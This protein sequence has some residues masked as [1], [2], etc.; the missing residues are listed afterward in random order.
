MA[1]I[2]STLPSLK[3]IKEGESEYRYIKN[4][5]LIL[6]TRYNNQLYTTKMQPSSIPPVLD[7]KL[8]IAIGERISSSLSESEFIKADGSIDFKGNQSHGGNNITGVNN[9]TVGNALDVDGHTTLDQVTVNTTDGS[10]AVSG[11]N[12][13]TLTTTGTNDIDITTAQN[14]DVGIGV[15]YQ[16]DVTRTCDWNTTNIDWDNSA[17]FDLT[18]VGDL[19]IETSGAASAKTILLFN[20]N[21]HASAFRGIH[22]KT[23][24]Q[25][26]GSSQNSIFIECD[27]RAAKGGGIGVDIRSEDGVLIRGED[28]T[29][30]DKSIVQI[31]ATGSVDIAGDTNSIT[32]TTSSPHRVKIHGAFDTSNLYRADPDVAIVM[33]NGT[34]AGGSANGEYTKFQALDTLHLVRAMTY[35]AS[36]TV[37][38]TASHPIVSAANDDNAAG[39]SW[40]ITIVWKH[41]S[42]DV[43][44]QL[45]M[46]SAVGSADNTLI[47]V[48]ISENLESAT[49]TAAGTLEWTNGA[50]IVWTNGHSDHSGSDATMKASALRIQSGTNDF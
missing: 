18:S 8:N 35:K 30:G 17:D 20:D 14:L 1:R 4:V 44:S 32:A 42:T 33:D 34:I 6:Y 37:A 38:R 45:W 29:N 47:S 5:G 36:A 10:F 16:L 49:G 41:A 24:S 50:G 22:L 39:T 7:K 3:E 31:R 46:C 27:N 9:L 19:T 26:A 15:D 21:N 23:D 2:K 48:K 12:P 25:N 28:A 43:N 40:L 11:A 13:I